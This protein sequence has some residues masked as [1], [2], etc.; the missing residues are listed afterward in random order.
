MRIYIIPKRD[1]T[2]LVAIVSWNSS[3]RYLIVFY[4]I[5]PFG[6]KKCAL[7]IQHKFYKGSTTKWQLFFSNQFWYNSYCYSSGSSYSLGTIYSVLIFVKIQLVSSNISSK[8]Y[9]SS[10]YPRVNY[11]HIFI[12]M[13]A[14]LFLISY[15]RIHYITI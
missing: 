10:I 11:F 4:D 14:N 6:H 13:A 2:G 9:F 15:L 3:H 5:L 1:V 7:V 12:Y 8:G